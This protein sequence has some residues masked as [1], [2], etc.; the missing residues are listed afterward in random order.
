MLWI[1]V[2][3]EGGELTRD[4]DDVAEARGWDDVAERALW[5]WPVGEAERAGPC[6]MSDTGKRTRT[7]ATVT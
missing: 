3:S 2:E 7:N 1:T 6:R 4:P 5:F